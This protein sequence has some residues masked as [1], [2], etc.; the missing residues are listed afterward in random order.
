[1]TCLYVPPFLTNKPEN[2]D[3]IF[4]GMELGDIYIFDLLTHNFGKYC[5]VYKNLR[6]PQQKPEDT[7]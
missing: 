6:L 2:H 4:I 5:I 1:M 7:D 3:H